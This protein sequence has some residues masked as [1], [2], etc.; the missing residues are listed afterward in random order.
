MLMKPN[1]W[2][3]R[4]NGLT[5]EAIRTRFERAPARI[6]VTES[7]C[8]DE[9]N[10]RVKSALT[11]IAVCTDGRVYICEF[12]AMHAARHTR[13]SYR[14]ANDFRRQI[15]QKSG[16]DRHQEVFPI[17][18]TGPAGI[19]K[20]TLVQGM[21]RVF[22][23][24][25]A[26]LLDDKGHTHFQLV[27][28]WYLNAVE[29]RTPKEMLGKLI[30]NAGHTPSGKTTSDWHKQCRILAYKSGVSVVFLDEL[31]FLTKSKDATARIMDVVYELA[32][33][34]IPIVIVANYSLVDLL[35]GRPPQDRQRVL[36]NVV[37]L[38]H[39]G[40]LSPGW[41]RIIDAFCAVAPE[42]FVL[43]PAEDAK[44]L[45]GL[46]AG[47]PRT[48]AKLLEVALSGKRGSLPVVT[49]ADLEIAYEST[50]FAIF[51]QDVELMN[52][53]FATGAKAKADLWCP[54][55]IPM[56]E[57]AALATQASEDLEAATMTQMILN[58]LSPRERAIYESV[59]NQ[60]P[61][62]ESQGKVVPIGKH[63][64]CNIKDFSTGE[65]IFKK[66]K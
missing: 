28:A 16:P 31:Q 1:P 55:P 20:S 59:K 40:A 14:D 63:R 57:E 51:R 39:D 25:T 8:R 33:L 19:G 11:K 7:M 48:L 45:H 37:V 3:E 42:I 64:Q 60:T 24:D 10:A 62:Q 21:K 4:F 18:L 23:Q 15:N 30:R 44:A 43:D 32:N 61:S 6:H 38:N 9:L 50:A 29:T 66:L 49:M 36:S 53:Q 56:E 26:I 27:S 35:L 52:L 22:P 12:F 47:T 41:Q 54:V 13:M 58:G 5:L 17:C 46:T 34:G 65:E 2:V